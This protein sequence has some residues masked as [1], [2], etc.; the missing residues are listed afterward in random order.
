MYC[1]LL[2]RLRYQYSK[3][4]QQTVAWSVTLLCKVCGPAFDPAVHIVMHVPVLAQTDGK[5]RRGKTLKSSLAIRATSRHR[6]VPAKMRLHVHA[7]RATR[8]E[9]AQITE[10]TLL[11]ARAGT[12]YDQRGNAGHHASRD[13]AT[14]SLAARS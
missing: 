8:D 6:E 14:V 2:R 1:A 13:C 3:P 4:A 5:S 10:I 7:T 12:Y 11:G 9:D